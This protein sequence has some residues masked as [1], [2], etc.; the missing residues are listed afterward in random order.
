VAESLQ[1]TGVE[2]SVSQLTKVP[3]T[4][5][6]LSASDAD[7]VV[8][9]IEALEDLDDVQNVYTNADLANAGTLAS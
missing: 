8:A 7:K 6:E 5:T 2:P 9:F 4:L 1:A 3:Q